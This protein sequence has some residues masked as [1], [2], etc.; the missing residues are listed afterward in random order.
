M[1]K[2]GPEKEVISRWE[3]LEEELA[4]EVVAEAGVDFDTGPLTLEPTRLKR[5]LP[6]DK[7]GNLRVMNN[8]LLQS[9]TQ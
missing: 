6:E 1:V 3:S 8:Q 5:I 9:H 4:L 7:T 2:R